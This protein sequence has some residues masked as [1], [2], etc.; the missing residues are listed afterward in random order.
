[1]TNKL[2]AGEVL[3]KMEAIL[4]KAA[5]TGDSS[6]IIESFKECLDIAVDFIGNLHSGTTGLN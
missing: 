1:V 4:A 2:S 6:K 3:I 5:D